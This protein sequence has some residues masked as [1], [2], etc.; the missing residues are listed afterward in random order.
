MSKTGKTDQTKRIKEFQIYLQEREN[1][2]STIEKYVRD[3]H[4]FFGFIKEREISKELLIAYKQW[5]LENYSVNSANSMLAALNQYLVFIELGRLRLKRIRVQRMNMQDPDRELGKEEFRRLVR[6]AREMEKEQIAM[7]METICATGIRVSELRF[8]RVED[9]RRG[10][11]KVWNK[12]KC[13]MVI[14]PRLLKQK[15]LAYAGSR[16]ICSGVIFRTRTGKAVDRVSIWK[17]MKN[18]AK[19]AGVAPGKVFPHNLRHLFSREFYKITKNLVNLADILG[20]SSL[21]VT[22]IY[23]SDGMRE[24]RRNLEK[25]GLILET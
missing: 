10:L 21:E 1:A 12:G 25:T 15:L 6:A 11:V 7:I 14:I 4:K 8:F 2:A 18:V 5:L 20:H 13:R 3:I 19:K 23:A 22:R 17:E 24:W 9:L 16:H